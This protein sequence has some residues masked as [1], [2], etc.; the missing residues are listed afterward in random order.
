MGKTYSFAFRCSLFLY[1]SNTWFDR[2][3]VVTN[4]TSW[5]RAHRRW[6]HRRGV[7]ERSE[8]R[9]VRAERA[10]ML[11]VEDERNKEGESEGAEQESMF[12]EL[13]Y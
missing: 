11:K 13:K 7:A 8:W 9:I 5:T 12:M 1:F 10:D 2:C 4:R 6:G 3:V